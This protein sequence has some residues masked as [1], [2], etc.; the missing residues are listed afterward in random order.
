MAPSNLFTLS[1]TDGSRGPTEEATKDIVVHAQTS[2]C[3]VLFK[4]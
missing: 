2:E 1:F 3:S 4:L